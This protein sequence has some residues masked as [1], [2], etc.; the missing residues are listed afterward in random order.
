MSKETADTK[1]VTSERADPE[2]GHPTLK[3]GLLM[4][5]VVLLLLVLAVAS[6]AGVR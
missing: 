1:T 2:P 3:A 4:A 6:T 5:G